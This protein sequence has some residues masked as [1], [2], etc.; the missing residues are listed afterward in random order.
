MHVQ[1]GKCYFRKAGLTVSVRKVE[2]VEGDVV[3]YRVLCGPQ[4]KQRDCN[5]TKLKKFVRW[6]TGEVEERDDYSHLDGCLRFDTFVVR[7]THGR[8]FFRCT[9]RKANV[10]LKKGYAVEVEPGVLQ[11]T[12]DHVE[13]RLHEVHDGKFNEFFLAVKNDRCVVCGAAQPLT[14]HHVVPRRVK[15]LVPRAVR[16]RLSN[17]LFVC[18]SCHEKYEQTSEPSLE[19][20]DDPLGFCR[21]WSEHFV[22]VL[23][24]RFMPAGWDVISVKDG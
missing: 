3:L 13:K 2:R 8:P 24:P 14:R 12:T 22:A 17:V 10:Y 19:V 6:A 9:Q 1:P 23:Q 21:A 7:D 4:L 18:V 20:G 16:A 11:M 15:K 5:S